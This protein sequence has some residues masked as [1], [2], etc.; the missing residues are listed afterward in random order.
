MEFKANEIKA[1]LMILISLATLLL[2]LFVIFGS[3]IGGET[4]EY[5]TYLGYVGGIK[6]GSL[7][8]YGGMDV[9]TVVDI[10]FPNNGTNRIGV[11]LKIDVKTPVKVDSKAFITSIGI[12]ADPHVEISTGSPRAELLPS[13]EILESKEVLSLSQMAEPLGDLNAQLQVLLDRVTE[14]FNED[15]QAHLASMMANMDQL[16][17]EGQAH[18]LNVVSNLEE[19]SA[20]LLDLSKEVDTIMENNKDNFDETLVNLQKTAKETTEIISELHTTLNDLQSMVS[21]NSMSFLEMMENFQFAS[22]NLAEFT[23]I[24]KERPW[25]L[26]RKDA[27]PKRKLP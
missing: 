7:V 17:G 23:R 1:G 16:I 9:G 11:R 3:R 25:M 22:Q 15:N 10:A 5:Q 2:F 27:P 24:V 13:G 18:F 6:K 19:L 21:A 8:K 14:L 4:K 20:Q 26:I 12:M